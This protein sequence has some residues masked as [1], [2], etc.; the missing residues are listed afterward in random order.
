VRVIQYNYFLYCSVWLELCINLTFGL[1]Q[2]KHLTNGDQWQEGLEMLKL[3]SPQGPCVSPDYHRQCHET[4][5]T[6]CRSKALSWVM[7]D[8]ITVRS[9]YGCPVT[10][11]GTCSSSQSRC[12]EHCCFSFSHIQSVLVWAVHGTRTESCPC[13]TAGPLRK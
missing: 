3:M 9:G 11:M 5:T 1:S 13:K 6:L 4:L 12:R 10:N 8:R 7:D 2:T